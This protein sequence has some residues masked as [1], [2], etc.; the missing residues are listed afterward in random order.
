MSKGFFGFGAV[1]A[2]TSVALA[3]CSGSAETASESVESSRDAILHGSATNDPKYQAVG[4]LVVDI[5]EFEFYDVICSATLVAPQAMVTARHCT[6]WIDLALELGGTP[7]LAFGPDAFAPEKL[8]PITSYVNAPPSPRFP[9]LLLDG[10]R[11]VAVAYLA[12]EPEGIVPAKLGHFEEEMLGTQFAI[13]GYGFND[14]MG[15]YG[16]KFA[17]PATARAQSGFWYR[18]LFDN[19]KQ[20]FLDWYF[21]EAATIPTPEEAEQWWSIYRLEPRYE[22]L[23]GGLPGEA[24]GCFGDSGGP[25]L[26]GTNASN[27]TI[28]GVSFA[29][30]A[31]FTELCTRGGAYA[32]FNKQMLD[33]VKDALGSPAC[34]SAKRA[35]TR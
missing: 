12:S 5:P 35:R 8:V 13:V 34:P 29:V 2:L 17:G 31:S 4:A 24:L 28:Y 32:V 1:I 22:L 20:A 30:E 7:Y 10:G 3:G 21:T 11:D 18:L 9:G 23:A 16:Q 27:L 14:P 19:D 33:F 25:I 6:P 26:R 15:F